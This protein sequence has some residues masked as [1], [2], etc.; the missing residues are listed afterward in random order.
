MMS[1]DRRVDEKN[2]S[3]TV[4]MRKSPIVCVPRHIIIIQSWHGTF[5][6]TT[7]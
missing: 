1:D 4:W 2:S 3:C 7:V 6:P 5:Y